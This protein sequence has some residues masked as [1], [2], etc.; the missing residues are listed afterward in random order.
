M[1]LR[2]VLI[3][4]TFAEAFD[5]S[6]ARV[7]V[8]AV[9]ARWARAAA[10][11]LTGFATSII[12]CKCEAAIERELTPEETPDGRP[13]ISALFFAMDSVGLGK[14]LVERIGHTVLTCPTT[15][16]FDGLP[17]AAERVTPGRALRVFGDRFQ[18]SKIVGGRRYWRVPVMEGEFLVQESFGV[19]KNGVGGG[20][21][22]ILAEDEASALA[23][24]EAGVAAMAEV[25]GVI[26]PFPGGV[27]RSGSKIGARGYASL[28]AST[29]DAYCPTLRAS[30]DSA[31]PDGVNSVLEF[32]LDGLDADA[33]RRA[34]RAGID[35]AC[36]PG[37]R[38]ITAGNYGGNLGKHKFHLH[39]I[40]NGLS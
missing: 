2:G 18:I 19:L 32:V 22:L 26:L 37:V 35:A 38:A 20:N 6:A 1:N 9:N 4:D 25:P 23:A 3:E 31:L 13:G 16:C 10:Q 15:S 7:V 8:T 14:R 11:A 5:M 28:I 40:M 27:A 17:D 30:T 36:R 34:M 33:I 24:A 21:F 29:N 39:A 12:A